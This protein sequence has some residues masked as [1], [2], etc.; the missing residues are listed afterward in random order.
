MGFSVGAA[1]LTGRVNGCTV[2]DAGG[3]LMVKIAQ[4]LKFYPVT[5]P[6]PG[7]AKLGVLRLVS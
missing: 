5:F 3:P 7:A 2:T 4:R 6:A 1:S